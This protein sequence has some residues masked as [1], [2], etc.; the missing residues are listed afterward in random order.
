MS[1]SLVWQRISVLRLSKS[2]NTNGTP[3]KHTMTLPVGMTGTKNRH[4]CDV[5]LGKKVYLI[6]KTSR[7]LPMGPVCFPILKG[8]PGG[9]MV[10][11]NDCRSNRYPNKSN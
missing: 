4:N 6:I 9:M 3:E 1:L 8:L 11:T 2:H 10:S 7:K 5:L